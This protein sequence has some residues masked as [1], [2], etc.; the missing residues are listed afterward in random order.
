MAKVKIQGH[1]SGSGVLTITAPNTSTDRT[2]TLPDATGTLLTADGDGSSLTGV[3]VDGISS[4]ADATAI[5][6]DSAENVGFGVTPTSFYSGYTGV[7]VGGNGTFYG[8]TAAGADK[9]LWLSQ[10]ARAGTDGSEKAIS[11]GTSSQIMMSSGNVTLK[12]GASASADANVTWTTGFEV[13]ADGKARA[14]NGLLFGTDTA[15]TNTLDDY[16]IGT[17]SPS[18]IGATFA[19]QTTTGR[20][21]KIGRLVHIQY[22]TA[23]FNI[24]SASGAA[25]IS[26][27][28]YAPLDAS[29][30]H[31][32]INY[33]HG[34][35]VTG[36]AHIYLDHSNAT[37]YFVTNDTTNSPS[38]TNGNSKY[39]MISGTYQT[40]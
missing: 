29:G 16:E 33:A 26:N 5:T 21:I 11:T 9:N 4:S 8:Q 7:Q 34:T 37:M 10:N 19:N 15:S 1:A 32:V 17:W 13:L 6:I 14:K 40:A 24:S 12:T 3:G 31:S 36:A 2:I 22:Y 30:H 27:L 39:V 38:W 18:L 28:P 35:A 25:R 20:Y 23:A